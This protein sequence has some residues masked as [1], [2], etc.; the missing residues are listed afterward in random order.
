MIR[1]SKKQGEIL[2]GVEGKEAKEGYLIAWKKMWPSDSLAVV[3]RLNGRVRV[4]VKKSVDNSKNMGVQSLWPIEGKCDI[5]CGT[6]AGLFLNPM[7][8]LKSEQ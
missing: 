3:L 8:W 4:I 1:L 2:A 5:E 7:T 6:V